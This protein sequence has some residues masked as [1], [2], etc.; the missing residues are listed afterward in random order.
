[1][2][3]VLPRPRLVLYAS[4]HGLFF[5]IINHML[6]RSKLF[7]FCF[8]MIIRILIR[9]LCWDF[10]CYKLI[11]LL[12]LR[13]IL[14]QLIQESYISA[15]NSSFHC[16]IYLLQRKVFLYKDEISSHILI[17]WLAALYILYFVGGLWL[18]LRDL[19]CSC[20]NT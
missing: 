14:N 1:M 15:H 4:W 9:G 19:T 18:F 13:I 2:L 10:V 7:G 5:K 8:P 17:N 11:S 6:Y 3:S 20:N 16:M 12:L